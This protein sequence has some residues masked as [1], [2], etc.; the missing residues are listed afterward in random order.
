MARLRFRDPTLGWLAMC[1]DWLGRVE[2]RDPADGAFYPVCQ[3]RPYESTTALDGTYA[4]I[5]VDT[6][7][8]LGTP[9]VKWHNPATDE[10]ESLCCGPGPEDLPWVVAVTT[11]QAFGDGTPYSA[12]IPGNVRPGDLAI[13]SGDSFG[14]HT[15][16]GGGWS[17]SG[18]YYYKEVGTEVAYTWANTSLPAATL[19]GLVVFMRDATGA[20]TYEG[21]FEDGFL[22][23]GRPRPYAMKAAATPYTPIAGHKAV[24][25]AWIAA[26][27][28]IGTTTVGIGPP[29]ITPALAAGWANHK[30]TAAG[31]A[32]FAAGYGGTDPTD[33]GPIS[34][35]WP[36]APGTA[37]GPQIALRWSVFR[38]A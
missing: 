27:G 31:V 25:A 1:D 14:D 6:Y 35:S 11:F 34:C 4:D 10:W 9:V 20:P 7:D 33:A 22:G 17:S 8:A 32:A 15:P 29:S 5:P 28:T 38:I 30:N 36:D 23:A 16:I 19:H 18:P 37:Y 24:Y 21:G 26:Y 12:P 3:A 13:I 2:Y